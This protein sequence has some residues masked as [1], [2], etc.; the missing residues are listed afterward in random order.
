MQIKIR[1]FRVQMN[2]LKMFYIFSQNVLHIFPGNVYINKEAILLA[3]HN[4]QLLGQL[5]FL[6]PK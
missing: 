2:F 3:I 5:I 4:A 1:I 6:H